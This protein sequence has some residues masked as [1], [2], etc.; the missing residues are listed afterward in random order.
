MHGKPVLV[1]LILISIPQESRETENDDAVKSL[2]DTIQSHTIEPHILQAHC[3]NAKTL[4][5]A[6]LKPKLQGSTC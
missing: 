4:D 5:T 1:N 3:A 6:A 2:V